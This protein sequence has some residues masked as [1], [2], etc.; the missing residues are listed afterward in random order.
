M[1]RDDFQ[2]MVAEFNT[3]I[4]SKRG[5][6]GKKLRIDLIEEEFTEICDAVRQESEEGFI[7]GLCDLLYVAYGAADVFDIS[8]NIADQGKGMVQ[9]LLVDDFYI[10]EALFDL[11]RLVFYACR[12]IDAEDK[13]AIEKTLGDVVNKSWYI[14]HR[15]LGLDLRP[16]FT[17]VHHANMLKTTGPIREDGKRLKPE[18]WMAPDIIG[19]YK[20]TLERKTI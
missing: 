13:A 11:S 12:A 15:C 19:L 2:T 10:P 3:A 9:T 7:D 5:F 8:L 20:K 18:G 17:M 14:G 4:E 6:E 1:K 16:F